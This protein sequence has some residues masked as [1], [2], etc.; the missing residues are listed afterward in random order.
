[1]ASRPV[2]PADAVL[3]SAVRACEGGRVGRGLGES[4]GV[5]GAVAGAGRE[6]G[7][8][9]FLSQAGLGRRHP[10]R[11]PSVS[12]TTPMMAIRGSESKE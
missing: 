6:K 7:S 3:G 4:E 10:V 12:F 8:R 11:G 9:P 1:M 2:G 5:G